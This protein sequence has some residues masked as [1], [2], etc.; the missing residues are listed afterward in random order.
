MPDDFF[1][2]LSQEDK[3]DFNIFNGLTIIVVDDN[4]DILVL[5]TYILESYGIEVLTVSSASAALRI[6]Q[7]SRVDLLISDIAMPEEDG[8]SLIE[9]VRLLT[10]T[11][12]R[13]IPAIALTAYADKQTHEKA[14]KSGFQICLNKPCSKEQ[15]LTQIAKLLQSSCR[16]SLLSFSDSSRLKKEKVA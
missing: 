10:P 16:S 11:P 9:K 13:E 8:Y 1:A 12:I 3:T 4:E 2:L 5:I 6:I 14:V 15:L 7:Q